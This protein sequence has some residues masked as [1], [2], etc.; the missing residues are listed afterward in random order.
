MF[1]IYCETSDGKT[2][3]FANGFV[4]LMPPPVLVPMVVKMEWTTVKV[5]NRRPS[6]CK[7]CKVAGVM[8]LAASWL[9]DMHLNEAVFKSHIFDMRKKLV[10][11][12]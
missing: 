6:R 9:H 7:V 8:E 2:L 5:V 11:K 10:G 1:F 3:P 4:L 12:N